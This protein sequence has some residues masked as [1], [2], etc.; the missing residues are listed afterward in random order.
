MVSP[1]TL[2]VLK[3]NSSRV[4]SEESL[5][6]LKAKYGKEGTLSR[7]VYNGQ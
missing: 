6:F 1:S 5:Y 7:L 2:N 4:I 3:G